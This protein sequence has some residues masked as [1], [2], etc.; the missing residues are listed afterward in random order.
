MPSPIPA[1][2]VTN[3]FRDWIGDEFNPETLSIDKVNR[4]H[5]PAHRRNKSSAREPHPNCAAMPK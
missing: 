1:I 4:L 3:E 5:S 2:H